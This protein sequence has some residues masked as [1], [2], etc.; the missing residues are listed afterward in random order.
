M[1]ATGK[2]GAHQEGNVREVMTGFGLMSTDFGEGSKKSLL[3]IGCLG[4]ARVILWFIS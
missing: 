3:W 1:H 2:Y 4:E